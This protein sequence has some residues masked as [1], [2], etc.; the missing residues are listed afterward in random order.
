MKNPQ[1]PAGKLPAHIAVIMDGNGR[2]ARKRGLPRVAGHKAGANALEDIV[3]ECS[4]LGIKQL[5]VYAFSSENWSRPQ[6]EVSAL[7]RLLGFFLDAK[8]KLF[9]KN[10]VRLAAI[11]Q[12][13]RLPDSVRKKLEGY[14]A[15]FSTHTGMTFCLALNYGSRQEIVDAVNSAIRLGKPVDEKSFSALLQTA[16]MPDPDL[17]IRT[18]GEMRLSNFMLWQASYSEFYFTPVLWP[19]F[20]VNE[21]HQALREYQQRE[22]RFGG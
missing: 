10:N 8:A 12:L 13:E 3:V 17:L 7:M 14:I 18:S 16:A 11:G 2:W 9:I 5:T 1:P 20:N 4:N 19:D 6:T 21:L 15:R 22:R